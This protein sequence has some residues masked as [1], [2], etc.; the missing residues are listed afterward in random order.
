MVK[1]IN[2]HNKMRYTSNSQLLVAKIEKFNLILIL[3]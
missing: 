1:N 2:Q 3:Q